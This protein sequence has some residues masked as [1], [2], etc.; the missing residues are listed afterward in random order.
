MMNS[1]LMNNNLYKMFM[2]M[3]MIMLMM[4]LYVMLVNKIFI[5]E[6]EF[7]NYT[8]MNFTVTLM[9]DVKGL[10]FSSVVLFITSNVMKFSILYMMEEKFMN[11]FNILLMLF[12]MSMNLLIFIPNLI[13]LLLGW[14]GLGIVSFILVIY[15]QN[16]KSLSAGLITILTNRLG[17]IAIILCIVMTMNQAHWNIMVMWDTP[18]YKLQSIMILVAAMTKS[19]QVPFSS[20]LPAAMAAPTPVSALVHSSTLVTAGV[21]LLIRFYSFLC[22]YEMLNKCLLYVSILTTLLASIC[23]LLENDMKKIV[24]LSTLSQLGLMMTTLSMGLL[25]LCFMHMVAHAMFKA[26]LFICVGILINYN[27]HSQD[28]RWIG[29]VSTYMPVTSTCMIISIMSMSGFPFLSAF[30]TKDIIMEFFVCYSNNLMI[31]LFMYIS[32]GLTI[33]YSTR[34][35][36]YILFSSINLM[37]FNMLM[38]EKNLMKTLILMSLPSVMMGSIMAWFVMDSISNMSLKF[39]ELLTPMIIVLMGFMMSYKFSMA[40]IKMKMFIMNFSSSMWFMVLMSTQMFMKT[41]MGL[42]KKYLK[43]LDQSWLEYNSGEGSFNMIYKNNSMMLKNL[44]SNPIKNNV[45]SLIMVMSFMILM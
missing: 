43:Y 32:I 5:I 7:F 39:N 30:Y 29:S 23:G 1:K 13:V 40:Y 12:V 26:M 14:D 24:A 35:M 25:N 20:W 44:T 3:S 33:S 9:L 22:K 2:L 8:L 41:F 17:D 6:W 34:L 15:Y 31:M 16:S 28:L 18:E 10:F 11:R 19:A 36:F 37:P 38:E 21:F 42:S 4:S 45:L 27:S